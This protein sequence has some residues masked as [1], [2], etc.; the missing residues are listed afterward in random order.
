VKIDI[1]GKVVEKGNKNF[2]INVDG[3][4]LKEEINEDS[5]DVK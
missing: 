2:G 5:K 4:M 1:K 3:L